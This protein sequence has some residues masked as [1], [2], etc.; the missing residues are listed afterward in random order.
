MTAPARQRQQVSIDEIKDRLIAQID[1]VVARYAPEAPG[2]YHKQGLYFTLNPGRADRKVGSFCVHMSG[3]KAGRWNDYAMSG[4]EASG[5]LLDLIQMSLNLPRAGDAIAEARRFLGLDTEDPATRRAAEDHA[6]RLRQQRERA[7]K[8][9]AARLDRMR[10]TAAAL[11]LSGQPALR[12]T[13]V[14][15]YLRGR[16]IDLAQLG[17]QPGAIRFHPECQY[18]G[19]ERHEVVDP[20]TGEIT[21]RTVRLPAVP[22]PAML[23]AITL[24]KRIIDC[25]RTYLAQGPDGW[26]KAPLPDAKKVLTDYTGGSIRLSSGLGPR[27]GKGCPL[28]DCPPGTKVFIS[29]GIENGLSAIVLRHLA[30]LP[31]E[32]VLAAGSVWNLGQI[33]LPANVAEVTLAA[34]NDTNPQAR[35]ALDR[36]IAAHKARG[37]LVRVWRSRT[38]GEDLNDALRRVLKEQA[39]LDPAGE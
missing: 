28:N 39:G 25:H 38:P 13:P 19:E 34:D 23:T 35:A 16:G 12:G 18:I 10:R 14:D 24:G 20:E 6:R 15:H 32:R 1:A 9:E 17:H 22:M 11:W 2:A 37:R 27:G 8:D 7:A 30:G 29:E 21:T 26:T 5:D 4:R 31:P 33:E 36:A 3:P